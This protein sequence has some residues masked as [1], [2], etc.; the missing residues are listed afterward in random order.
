MAVRTGNRL[1]DMT[2][3]A[4]QVIAALRSG[5]DDLGAYAGKLDES[6][7]TGP[8]GATEWDV[9]HVLS[10]LGSG[11]EISLAT[12]E[13]AITGGGALPGGFNQG[14]W[15]R[16]N[17][18][19][20]V[21][22]R[23]SFLAANERLVERYESLDRAARDE[24]R[25]D[26]G[27]LPAPVSVAAAGQLRLSEFTLHTWDV[28]VGAEPGTTL[29][30]PAVPLL[31]DA[32]VPLLRWIAKPETL[33]GRPVH[34]AVELSDP[35]GAYGLLL[36]DSVAL[37]DRPEVADGVL[38]APAE[39]WLRLLTGRLAAAY[40]PAPVQISGPVT[41]DDLRRVFPGF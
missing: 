36:G 7:L 18:M 38:T 12:L 41:L 29:A 40:T 17:A 4:D 9:S 10:H 19:G 31:Q 5:H 34:L 28:K 24:L 35:P 21:E 26:L 22:H 30:S 15:D 39:A 33:P 13:Q 37:G 1:R 2:N 14:V 23:D 16:W 32:L 11:A 25:I 6:G 3:L 27:F 20:P 8:S